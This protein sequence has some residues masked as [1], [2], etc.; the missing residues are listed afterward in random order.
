ML[1][2]SES[3][4]LYVDQNLTVVRYINL[5]PWICCD[6]SAQYIIKLNVYHICINST[7]SNKSSFSILLYF[8]RTN[9]KLNYE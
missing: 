6:L 4:K 2:Q 1:L 9:A 7:I 3:T 5:L 8:S